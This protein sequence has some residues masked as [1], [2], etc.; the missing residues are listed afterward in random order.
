MPRITASPSLLVSFLQTFA[1][2]P[3]LRS[4]PATRSNGQSLLDALGGQRA[5]GSQVRR[6]P[7]RGRHLLKLAGGGHLE[8]TQREARRGVHA[9]GPAH[10]PQ[11]QGQLEG[12]D[13]IGAIAP[14]GGQRTI[15]AGRSGVRSGAPASTARKSLPVASTTASTPFMIPLLW[16]AARYGSSSAKRD[17][18]TIRSTISAPVGVTRGGSDPGPGASVRSLA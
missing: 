16:V 6:Q 17:A 18:S 10:D 8:Q 11:R 9:Q 14:P 1:P 12:A 13:Q 2:G 4:F 5:Q 15:A 7:D 3:R